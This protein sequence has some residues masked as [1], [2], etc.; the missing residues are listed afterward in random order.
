MYL[1][2]IDVSI[3]WGDLFDAVFVIRALLLKFSVY[4]RAP[5][6]WKLLYFRY[7][8]YSSH[9]DD[10]RMPLVWTVSGPL[11]LCRYFGEGLLRP[12]GPDP[13]RIQKVEAPILVDSN[14]PVV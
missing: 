5:A 2:Y 6:S 10:Q 1:R 14:T 12:Q 11:L 7:M 8:I 9:V 3:N 13:E 4:S